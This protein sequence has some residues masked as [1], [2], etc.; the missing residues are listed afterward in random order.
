MEETGRKR[1][2]IR[3]LDR[4]LRGKFDLDADKAQQSEAA[5]NI[6]QF[7]GT[8]LWVLIFATFIVSLRKFGFMVLVSILI[9]AL[10]FWN[11]PLSTAQSELLART[12]LVIHD[13]QIAF[14]GGS[15][16]IVAA[17]VCMVKSVAAEAGIDKD[18][19]MKWLQVRARSP[20][21]KIYV[22]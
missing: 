4:C 1:Y 14:F 2:G 7:R 8:N 10:C 11:S 9:S 5:E 21:V 12:G 6:A 20:K 22:E 13:V 3:A 19:L 16:G 15:A 17:I 18:K